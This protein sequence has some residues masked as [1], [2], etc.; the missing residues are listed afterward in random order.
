MS[1]TGQRT[2]KP[3]V[4][5]AEQVFYDVGHLLRRSGFGATLNEVTAASANGLAA[6]VDRVVGYDQVQD[7]F[8]PPD[9]TY[10]M[11][12]N[13]GLEPLTVWWLQRMLTTT[14]PFQEKM[15]LFWHNHFATAY[16]KVRYPGFLYQQNQLFRTSALAR[17]DDL[18]GAIYKDPAMLFWLDGYRN[19]KAAPNENFAR[20]VMEL[21]TTGRGTDSAPNYTEN[22]IHAGAKAFTGWRLNVDTG[23][24]TFVP[25]QHD[26]TM[27]TFMGQTGNWGADD[28]IRILANHSA[29]G[30]FLATKLW[31]F[32]GSES[33]PVSAVQ[34]MAS[35]YYSSN[36]NI[37]A[38]VRTMF[39]SP[40]FYS[41]DTRQ[42][43]I[44]NPTDFV[45]SALHHLGLTNV[46]LTSYPRLLSQMGQEL[47]NPPNV[48]GWPGGASWIN[49]STMLTR[50]NFASRLVGD[51][52]GTKSLI[53]AAAIYAASQVDTVPELVDFVASTLGV[54]LSATTK[55][56]LLRYAGGGVP[57]SR[58]LAWVTQNP[59]QAPQAD[60]LVT[61]RGLVHL[62]L[63]SPEYQLA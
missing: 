58:F 59:D 4:P 13:S 28:I 19:V 33:P 37:G 24:V 60:P 49:A 7:N 50:F 41:Q 55:S 35:T 1:R 47:F 38:M 6:T 8:T 48:G 9:M 36:H 51:A 20:E 26:V 11:G 14:R 61:I 22:D 30:G 45:V 32:F 53:D 39:T 5:G 15:T 2:S 52:P 16:Y 42:S 10:L 56:A 12:K 40:E 54:G 18:L 17:F 27:K 34:A 57:F 62:T 29:T 25:Q 46:D 63:I 3:A 31:R 21:F 23:E 43:H 44:K